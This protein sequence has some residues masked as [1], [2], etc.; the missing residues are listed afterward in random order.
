MRKIFYADI[1][2]E[3]KNGRIVA[4][5]FKNPGD[6][7]KRAIVKDLVRKGEQVDTAYGVVKPDAIYSFD[8][9]AEAQQFLD[10]K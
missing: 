2:K 5:E 10:G 7:P 8:A 1:R 6:V 3:W 4:V 9:V